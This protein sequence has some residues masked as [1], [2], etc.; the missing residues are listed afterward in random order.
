MRRA[1]GWVWGRRL[2]HRGA[3]LEEL[4]KVECDQ[5][6]V[7]REEALFALPLEGERLIPCE[8]ELVEGLWQDL[9]AGEGLLRF[10]SPGG[11]CA[12]LSL[13]AVLV[14]QR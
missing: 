7:L 4:L 1:K 9:E 14:A 5:M 13:D 3:G 10:R 8:T 6:V 2:Q 11:A 12:V